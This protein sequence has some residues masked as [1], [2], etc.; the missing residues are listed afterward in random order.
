L[1]RQLGHLAA[2]TR[3]VRFWEMHPADW[4]CSGDAYVLASPHEA[5]LYLPGGGKVGVDMQGLTG[6]FRAKWLNPR[7]GLFSEPSAVTG[8]EMRTFT[9]PDLRDW[10]FYLQKE[11]VGR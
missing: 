2:F 10:V 5:I 3:Q 6:S 4:V 7:N 8:G 9:A 1:R 11:E